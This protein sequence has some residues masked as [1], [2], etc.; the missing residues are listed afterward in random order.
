MFSTETIAALA[1]GVAL[2]VLIPVIA[3]IMFK[4]KNPDSWLPSVFIG[5]ST[6]IVFALILEQ[7]LHTV[8]IPILKDN[9]IIYSV[10]GALAAG[11]FEETGR[12][13]AYKTLM[14]KHYTTKNAVLMGLGHGGIEA[15]IA[16]GVTLAMLLVLAV[17]SNSIGIDKVLEMTASGN[18][19]TAEA[20]KN[21]LETQLE[22]LTEYNFVSCALGVYERIVAMILHTCMSVFVYKAVTQKG[23][24]WLYPTAILL[25]ALFDFPAALYQTNVITSISVIY[26][27][28]TVFTAIIAGAAVLMAKKM[29]DNG[30]KQR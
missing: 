18:P 6:F 22:G 2:A 25:H 24:I 27:I 30:E 10:Y 23:K 4:K 5:A 19:G 7:I 29:P 8:M 28:M 9:I 20:L 15:I 14:K 17:M 16:L 26:I 13:V 3:V 1:V 21:P 11:V 12:F